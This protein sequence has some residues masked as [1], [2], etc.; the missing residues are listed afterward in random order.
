MGRP[1]SIRVRVM[2]ARRHGGRVSSWIVDCEQCGRIH[3]ADGDGL[4]I[5]K[6]GLDYA[7]KVA[8][9]HGR[10]DHGGF[11]HVAVRGG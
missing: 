2:R 7:K 3:G 10:Q 8:A 11:A 1:M 6:M 5:M 9:S 4:P